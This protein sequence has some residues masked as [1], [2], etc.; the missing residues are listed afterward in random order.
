VAIVKRRNLILAFV[1]SLPLAVVAAIAYGFYPL[2][3]AVAGFNH[4]RGSG[5]VGIW[6]VASALIV[7]EPLLFAAV[8]ALLEMR[9][10]RG[11]G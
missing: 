7:I 5:V 11:V 6:S 3:L 10:K 4:G 1:L 9:G 2:I 8:F